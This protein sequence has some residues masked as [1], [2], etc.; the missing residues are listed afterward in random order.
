MGESET[1]QRKCGRR[2]SSD[3]LLAPPQHAE[4]RNILG[5]GGCARYYYYED[6]EHEEEEEGDCIGPE[7]VQHASVML[8]YSFPSRAH[9]S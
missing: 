2:L 3:G 1:M 9:P 5:S 6:E 7:H 4:Q 8:Q